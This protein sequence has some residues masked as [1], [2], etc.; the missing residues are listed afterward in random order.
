MLSE[1]VC[2]KSAFQQWHVTL[3]QIGDKRLH[4]FPEIPNTSWPT[5]EQI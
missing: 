2:L 5:D 3:L 1:L 4:I